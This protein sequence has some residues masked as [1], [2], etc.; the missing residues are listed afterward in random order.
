[1][2]LISNLDSGALFIAV[3]LHFLL[4]CDIQST[5]STLFTRTK[6]WKT[7]VHINFQPQAYAC[8]Q[9]CSG[10]TYQFPPFD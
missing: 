4:H 3:D 8:P 5:T 1:M 7:F 10:L 2:V 6:L 9:L